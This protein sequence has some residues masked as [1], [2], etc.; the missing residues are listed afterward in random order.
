M[1][2]KPPPLSLLFIALSML[3]STTTSSSS[4]PGIAIYWGQNGKEGT[5]QQACATNNYKIVILAFLTVFGSGR[6]PKWNFAGHCG[7]WSPCTKLAPQIH[8]CQSQNIKVFL[9]LGGGIGHYSLS[10]PQDA[11]E[12]A[13]YL[14]E[15]FLSGQH[16]PL[17][18]V[19]LDG[20]DFDIEEGS[21]LF[22]DDLV[23]AINAFSTKEKRIYLS[24]APQCPYPDHYLD[25]AIKTGLFDYIWVQFYNNPPCQYSNG[26]PKKLFEYWDTWTSSVLPNNTVLLG[27][28]AAPRA[29]GSGFVA[30][31]VVADEIL[32]YIR[33]GSNYGGVMLWSRYYD[34]QTNFSEKIKGSLMM[35][36]ALKLVKAIGDGI[37]EG[38]FSILNRR[39]VPKSASLRADV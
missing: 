27:L 28:P 8:Y 18:S 38:L 19:A 36:S 33:K 30:A 34:V 23:K 3:S 20:I 4:G 35:R 2:S 39:Y 12:V 25:K 6:T 24:A 37:Y 10:S 15:S 16:G 17:G 9:S 1:A 13:L 11:R 7:D 22:Y 32:P 26:N 21:N 14:F 29:A 5:L 31:E